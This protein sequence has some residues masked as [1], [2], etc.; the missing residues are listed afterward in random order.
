MEHEEKSEKAQSVEGEIE[1]RKGL[2]KVILKKGYEDSNFQKELSRTPQIDRLESEEE[3]STSTETE[4][5]KVA[6]EQE[7]VKIHTLVFDNSKEYERRIEMIKET[8]RLCIQSYKVGTKLGTSIELSP[9]QTG[10]QFF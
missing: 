10:Q 5:P 9:P 3:P 7:R 6:E 8:T 1:H 4:L 2:P